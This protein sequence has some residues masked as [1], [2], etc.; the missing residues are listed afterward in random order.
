MLKSVTIFLLFVFC[1]F[2]IKT[3]V[4]ALNMVANYNFN[5][6]ANKWTATNGSGTNT[7]GS[8]GSIS[9]NNMSTFTYNG[10]LSSQTAWQ[11]V[12]GSTKKLAYV[13]NIGQTLTAPGS[14]NVVASG[15]L[16]Y[17]S[18]ASGWG[19]GWVRVDMY[20]QA[21]STYVANIGCTLITANKAW[22]T[23]NLGSTVAL[24]GGTTY[25]VRVSMYGKNPTSTGAAMTFGVDN[26][27]VN[28]APVGLA[29]TTP[30]ATTNAQFPDNFC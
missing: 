5:G 2:Q 27:D 20:N 12:T 28:F 29:V 30:I 21:N 8:T 3:R 22:T 18:T 11:A 14:G 10:A 25:F 4:F 15:K 19:N 23:M 7:C 9:D 13:G 16:S 17:Y 1:F 6:N 26:I 24:T